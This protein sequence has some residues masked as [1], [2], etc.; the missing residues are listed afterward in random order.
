MLNVKRI[1]TPTKC[2]MGGVG[3]VPPLGAGGG[4]GGGG[5]TGKGGGGGGGELRKES[6]PGALQVDSQVCHGS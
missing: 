4:G 5:D 3:G 6:L 1:R 2:C